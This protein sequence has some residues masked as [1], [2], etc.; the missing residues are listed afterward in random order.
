LYTYTNIDATV[1]PEFFFT[2]QN[3]PKKHGTTMKEDA[4]GC[5]LNTRSFNGELVSFRTSGRQD[6]DL[7]RFA[8]DYVKRRSKPVCL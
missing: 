4:L 5:A 1:L 6:T 8:P 7:Q 3:A 2:R